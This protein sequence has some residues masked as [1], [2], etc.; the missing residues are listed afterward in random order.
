MLILS[1]QEIES[2]KQAIILKCNNEV[3]SYLGAGKELFEIFFPSAT[4]KAVDNGKSGS[5]K[6]GN[7]EAV[8]SYKIKHIQTW[9]TEVLTNALAQSLS[10]EPLDLIPAPMKLPQVLGTSVIASLVEMFTTG[11]DLAD[12]DYYFIS[13]VSGALSID[14]SVAKKMID[15][16]NYHIRKE[17][18]DTLTHYLDDEQSMQCAILLIKAI[19]ADEEVHPA[20]FKYIENI[21]QLLKNDQAKIELAD[22]LAESGMPKVFLNAEFALYMFKYLTEIVMCDGE[23]DARESEF[24]QKVGNAFGYDKNKQDETIQ[25]VAGSL[26]VKAALFPRA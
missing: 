18:F 5:G 10:E 12:N 9:V 24:L 7:A 4:I 20:E 1:P 22:E 26:M 8:I 2:R 25:P 17:F 3:A 11:K 6:S 21:S 15:Q 16:A 14:P 13:D 23:Y 19:R